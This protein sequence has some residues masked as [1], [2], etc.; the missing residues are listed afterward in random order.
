MDP[1]LPILYSLRPEGIRSYF[2]D[3]VIGPVAIG[4][5]KLAIGCPIEAP[6]DPFPAEDRRMLLALLVGGQGITIQETGFARVGFLREHHPD[7]LLL[8]FVGEHVNESGMGQLDKVLVRPF[9]QV[10]L[11]FPARVAAYHEGANP[12]CDQQINDKARDGMQIML[13]PPIAPDGELFHPAGAAG[14][15]ESL[16]EFCSPLVIELVRAFQTAPV[17]DDR[18]K[19]RF[20]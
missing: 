5:D 17:N 12:L 9:P 11:L 3:D 14:V 13:N 6:S 1:A 15:P 20:V 2:F 8:G 18:D 10:D 7:T 4:V 16:L 19:T